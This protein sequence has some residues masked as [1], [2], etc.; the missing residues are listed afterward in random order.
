MVTVSDPGPGFDPALAAII[1]N[2]GGRH[3]LSLIRAA[4][5]DV[6]W[7]GRGNVCQMLLRQPPAEEVAKARRQSSTSSRLRR[8][9]VLAVAKA[10]TQR[11]AAEG[12]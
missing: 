12:D 10:M 9:Q 3:G 8:S 4:C 5:D 2:D 1:A 11:R 6:R 7:L